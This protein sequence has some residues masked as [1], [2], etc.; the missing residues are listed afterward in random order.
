MLTGM[1]MYVIKFIY[2][3]HQSL[4]D[5]YFETYLSNTY[6]VYYFVDWEYETQNLLSQ[7]LLS[8]VVIKIIGKQDHLR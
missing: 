5:P 4:S 8:S 6:Y 2:N 3:I 1:Y 7:A